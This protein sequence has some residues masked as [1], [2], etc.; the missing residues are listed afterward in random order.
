[1]NIKIVL[2][3]GNSKKVLVVYNS[4]PKLHK[5]IMLLFYYVFS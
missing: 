3:A 4:N 5:N 2:R 1:M